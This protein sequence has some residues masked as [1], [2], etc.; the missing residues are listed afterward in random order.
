[1]PV[2]WAMIAGELEKDPAFAR[3]FFSRIRYMAYGGAAMS[4]ELYDRIQRLS[5]AATGQ[6]IAFTTGYG[7]TETAPTISYVGWITERM[8]LIGLPLPGVLMKLA[9][10]GD[11]YEARVKGPAI[12]PGYFKDPARTAEAF[13]EE[14]FYRLGD[15]VR[16]VDPNDISRG[17]IFDGR[18]VEDFK[19]DSGTFVSAGV[20]RV[21]V[22][23]AM[24]GVAQD[25]VVC[26]QD[27]REVS[28]LVFLSPIGAPQAAGRQADLA[29]LSQDPNV[30]NAVRA[31][32]S[33][34]NQANPG[35]ATRI[36]RVIILPDAPS[37]AGG[38]LTDKGYINQAAARDK[39]AA[40]VQRL[41][42]LH[43]DQGVLDF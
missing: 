37:P 38:E 32:I 28:L 36:G 15:A 17:V 5:V 9:P 20:L 25:A 3:S 24:R 14:G 7:A 30:I 21:A 29:E 31:G 39:R 1:V 2:G 8:G 18:L 43:P 19:L 42:A 23:G 26:G 16:P 6:R 35:S 10:V 12:T 13:D 4:Q 27:Q 11:K 22:V 33:A 34:H 40:D 41:F